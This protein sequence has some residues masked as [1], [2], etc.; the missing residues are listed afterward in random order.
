MPSPRAPRP[1]R[2][3]QLGVALVGAWVL[4]GMSGGGQ[5]AVAPASSHQ[6]LFTATSAGGVRQQQWSGIIAYT[7]FEEPARADN[8]VLGAGLAYFDTHNPCTADHELQLNSGQ[9]PVAHQTC[10]TGIYEAGFHSF[11]KS[12]PA[13]TGGLCDGD[14]VGVIGDAT[15]AQGGG[16]GGVAPHGSQCVPLSPPCNSRPRVGWLVC[17]MQRRHRAE[18]LVGCACA[19]RPLQS[20]PLTAARRRY[21]MIEDAGA[22]FVYVSLDP[23][24]VS[25]HT[26]VQAKFWLNVADE[27]WEATD[28]I[29][30]WLAD[31]SGN[32]QVVIAGIGGGVSGVLAGLPQ[33]QWV[34]RSA[35]LLSPLTLSS[36][37]SLMFGLQ[38]NSQ[39]EEAWFDYLRIEGTGERPPSYTY[40]VSGCQ[41][42]N[43]L[44][45][46]NVPDTCGPC[47]GGYHA[48]E[49]NDN[50]NLQCQSCLSLH[51][52][53]TGSPLTRWMNH[54]RP[55]CKGCLPGFVAFH[56]RANTAC[57]AE[58]THADLCPRHPLKGFYYTGTRV[59]TCMAHQ[60]T[61]QAPATAR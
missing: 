50:S 9:A 36:Q 13:T 42:L 61:V 24:D 21:F 16:G 37:V 35:T 39:D 3:R 38:S 11:Y 47:A 59:I 19:A 12:M 28:S 49:A 30:I 20:P 41:P 33:G 53:D 40:L 56:E 57:Y 52:A 1:C 31:G 34:E 22:G 32:E 54:E 6:T 46:S 8:V 17:W 23:V 43:R 4:L 44:G 48:F 7:S 2:A 29:K 60:L 55:V 18:C 58:P 26:G 15:T 25:R 5:L 27:N 10:T 51:R 45:C 14:D